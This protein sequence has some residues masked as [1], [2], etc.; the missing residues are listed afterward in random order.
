[1]M[2]FNNVPI[3]GNLSQ[4]LAEI[5][6]D[7]LE[8]EGY[9]RF[10]PSSKCVVLMHIHLLHSSVALIKRLI[11]AKFDPRSIVII[12]KI[13]STIDAAEKRVERLGCVVVRA[14]EEQFP[15]GQYD[16]FANRALRKGVKQA[17]LICYSKKS[18][19]CIIVDDGGFLTQHW[20]EAR[21]DRDPFDAVSIQQ[22]A[23]GLYAHRSSTVRR[24]NVGGC[25]AKRHFESK[26]I[27][28]G[29]LRKLGRLHVL[30]R[31]QKIG[32]IGLGS[33]GA[34]IAKMLHSQG[35]ELITFDIKRERRLPAVARAVSWQECVSSVNIVLGCS[36]RNFMHFEVSD[37]VELASGKYFMSLSS[38]DVEFKSLLL[39]DP[40]LVSGNPLRD[41]RLRFGPDCS[42]LI[43]NGG[44]PINFDRQME[45]ET[46]EDISLTRGLVFVA[47]L[48]ALCVDAGQDQ[49]E[50][51]KLALLYQ[52]T[53]VAKWLLSK[54]KS[55]IDFDVSADNFDDVHWWDRESDGT[56]YD[57]GS[58][59]THSNAT[60]HSFGSTLRS[61]SI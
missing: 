38:R 10:V 47:I 26:I 52:R 50:I 17:R 58:I 8:E 16:Y 45:W 41:L 15:P 61:Q 57:G 31:R 53:L 37:A 24:I 22:T 18:D 39:A 40:K 7:G 51:E 6:I 56:V 3:A 36:G 14:R 33:V 13:Y 25:A 32:I 42:H 48:Q 43:A 34:S 11:E 35:H 1:M 55:S 27:V 12:P 2:R 59:S 21:E 49:S 9:A 30:S 29:V 19:R 54:D 23:S 5:D 44:F 28:A 46:T 4:F 20:S 60:D